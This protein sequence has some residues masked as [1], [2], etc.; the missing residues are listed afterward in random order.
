MLAEQARMVDRV[1]GASVWRLPVTSIERLGVRA[2]CGIL[3]SAIRQ[4]QLVPPVAA[5]AVTNPPA[6]AE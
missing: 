6:E 5:E 1:V 3:P 2:G 4:R